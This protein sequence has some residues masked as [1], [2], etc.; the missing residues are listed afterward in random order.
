MARIFLTGGGGYIGG[1]LASAL[2]ARGDEVVG[3]ARS[4]AAA[5]AL[6]AR[7]VEVVRGDVLDAAALARGMADCE[8]AY[9][10]A[11]VNSHC[12]KD[13]ARLTRVNVVGTETVVRAAARA[14]IRRVVFT[15]SAASV[16]EA[17]GTVGTEE[18]PHRGSYL[19][20]YDRSK[21]DAERVAFAVGAE[22]GVEVLA[23]NPSSVQGPPRKGG[24]GAII[25]AYLNG[26]LRAF[27]ETHVSVVDVQDVVAAHLLAAAGGSAGERYILNG[28]TLPSAEAL[29]LVSELAGI[30]DRVPMVPPWLARGAATLVESTLRLRGRTSP[31]CRARVDTILHGHRY[32]GSRAERELGLRYTPVAETFRRTIAWAVEEGLV[33][34]PLPGVHPA[35]SPP[36]ATRP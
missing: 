32:D 17:Q 2:R 29:A 22:T 34:R 27:V 20:L 30:E 16:G 4:D 18:S 8:L 13:P 25:I 31:I 1:A 12:P 28:A 23:L 21:H 24:N 7:D 14:G 6:A 5:R 9:H 3:L 10:V 36:W 33:T 26:R 15:S 35:G 11:G 19:S